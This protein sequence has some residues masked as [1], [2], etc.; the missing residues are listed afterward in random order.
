MRIIALLLI[1]GLIVEVYD[2]EVEIRAAAA[3]QPYICTA[4]TGPSHSTSQDLA[5]YPEF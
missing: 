5:N 3:C 1:G 2:E 4:I